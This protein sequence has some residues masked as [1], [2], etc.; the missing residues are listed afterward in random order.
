MI[1]AS[2]GSSPIASHSLTEGGASS[3]EASV[4]SPALCVAGACVSSPALSKD[5]SV[6]CAFWLVSAFA[7]PAGVPGAHPAKAAQSR[8]RG[9]RTESRRRPYDPDRV[10]SGLKASFFCAFFIL[11]FFHSSH[12][13]KAAG[14]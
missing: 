2:L 10:L 6:S 12:V 11:L 3:D 4:V 14:L 13:I 9:K 8:H 1:H 7:G 5:G